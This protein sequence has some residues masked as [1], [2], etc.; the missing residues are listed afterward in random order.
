[1]SI[2]SRCLRLA[3]AISK[4]AF[5]YPYLGYDDECYTTPQGGES[6]VPSENTTAPTT[7]TSA[8]T[9]TQTTAPTQASTGTASTGNLPTV[10]GQCDL[11]TVSQIG[12]RLTD[13]TTGQDIAGSGSAITYADGGYQVSYDTETSVQDWSVGD[14]VNLCLVS[15]P[16]DCPVGDNRGWVYQATNLRTGETWEAELRTFVRWSLKAKTIILCA[17]IKRL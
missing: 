15:I 4:T 2:K 17:Q 3:R 13:G 11:T 7:Q 1:M 5:S 12:T 9:N 8:D 6:A 10:V 16:T 14:Q